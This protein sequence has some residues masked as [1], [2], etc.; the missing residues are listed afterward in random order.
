MP[1]KFHLGIIPPFTTA[2]LSSSYAQ[3]FVW[4]TPFASS[5]WNASTLACCSF[6][7]RE[8]TILLWRTISKESSCP[9]RRKPRA[10]HI[11]HHVYLLI[12]VPRT[13]P[14]SLSGFLFSL[15]LVLLFPIGFFF[16]NKLSLTSAKIDYQ[17][18]EVPYHHK[19]RKVIPKGRLL[20][21]EVFSSG[22]THYLHNRL[23]S[24]VN[25]GNFFWRFNKVQEA[26]Q[27]SVYF[28]W[29]SNEENTL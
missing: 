18:W 25:D 5:L 11:R 22:R 2:G 14:A 28:S 1:W 6:T 27:S 3:Q 23:K 16:N 19:Q 20:Q 10:P 13:I 12:Q 21:Q 29:S 15:S 9:F 24:N 17:S 8:S 26:D 7:A 4:Q